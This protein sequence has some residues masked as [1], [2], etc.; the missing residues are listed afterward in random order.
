MPSLTWANARLLT[1]RYPGSMNDNQ[2]H[3]ELPEFA[4]YCDRLVHSIEVAREAVSLRLGHEVELAGLEPID[5]EGHAYMRIYWRRK[6]PALRL[7]IDRA[8]VEM[9]AGRPEPQPILLA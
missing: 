9:S 2:P 1:Y 3:T 5:R 8:G 6:G 7:A 4:T